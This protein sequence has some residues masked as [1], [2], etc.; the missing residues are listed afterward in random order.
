LKKKNKIDKKLTEISTGYIDNIVASS[1]SADNIYTTGANWSTSAYFNDGS[2]YRNFQWPEPL[3]PF[4]CPK[5]GEIGEE[6]VQ[7]TDS[8]GKEH[9]YCKKCAEEI[10]SKATEEAIRWEDELTKRDFSDG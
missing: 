5:H 2:G 10:L 6:V 3:P 7:V 1:I 8:D 4:C 9:Y